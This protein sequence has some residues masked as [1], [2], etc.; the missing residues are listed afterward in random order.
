MNISKRNWDMVRKTIYDLTNENINYA[1]LSE[2][3]IAEAFEDPRMQ[4]WL[5]PYISRKGLDWTFESFTNFYNNTINDFVET[6]I[7]PADLLG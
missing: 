3:V 1:N 2:E 5:Q 6:G 7:I 4:K